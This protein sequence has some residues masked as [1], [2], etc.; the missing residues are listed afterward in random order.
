MDGRK[1]YLLPNLVIG[2]RVALAFVAVGL[3]RLGSPAATGAAIA[4][5][6]V[7]IG[8]DGLDGYLAR[9]LDLTSELGSVLDITADRIVEHMFWIAFAVVGRVGLWVPLLIMTRSF[10]VDAARGMALIHGR[11]AFG[12]RSMMR[13]ATSRFLTGSRFMRT[14][15]AAAKVA[16]FVLLGTVVLAVETNGGGWALGAEA[17]HGLDLAAR[18]SVWVAVTLCVVRG[19]PVVWDSRSYITGAPGPGRVGRPA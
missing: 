18:A 8:L 6:V 9:R 2:T 5:I 19:V 13:S 15:Y 3:L 10:V 14:F 7:A 11:T 17:V 16:A 1:S 12:S 4:L